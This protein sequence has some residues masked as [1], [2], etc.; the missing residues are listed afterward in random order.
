[1]ID[2]SHLNFPFLL[3][4]SAMEGAVVVD[5]ERTFTAE[6]SCELEGMDE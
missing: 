4:R 6:P 5:P 2:R 3:G 1:L